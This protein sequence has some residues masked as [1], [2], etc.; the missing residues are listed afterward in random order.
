MSTPDVISKDAGV[1]MRSLSGGFR[2]RSL[3]YRRAV[4]ALALRLAPE[5][6]RRYAMHA[7]DRAERRTPLGRHE[8]PPDV[9]QRVGSQR[10]AGVSPLLRAPVHEPVFADVE[11]PR[12][13]PAVPV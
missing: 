9:R 10:H 11:V 3:S 2:H 4:T 1:A 13:G 6:H 7:P 5:I 12:A 8:L